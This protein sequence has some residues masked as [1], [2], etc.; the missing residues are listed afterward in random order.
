M[1]V[2]FAMQKR[3]MWPL[4]F[5]RARR[6]LLPLVFGILC[7]V[8][9]HVLI[10]QRYYNQDLVYAPGPGHL[11]FLANI[12]IYTVLLAPLLYILKRNRESRIIR[13]LAE[14]SKHPVG[15]LIIMIP[16][17]LETILVN[18]E[19]F[20]LYAG[21][22]HGFLYGLLAF[23]FGFWFALIEDAFRQLVCRW[24]WL[25][26][27]MASMLFT[28]RLVVFELQ[29]PD[30]MMSVESILWIFTALGFAAEYLDRS[31]RVLHYLSQA[32]YPVYIVHMIFLYLGSFLVFPM[33]IP[34][35]IKL[36]MLLAITIIASFAFYEVIIRR[37]NII[38]L[39]FGLKKIDKAVPQKLHV[40]ISYY[41]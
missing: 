28:V 21:T 26:A 16:F 34:A 10:W 37:R 17:V 31:G 18:P 24:R 12:F 1:G 38:R 30:Y 14:R 13:W 5:E 15:L 39:L 20:A 8:P 36:L 27:V 7:I 41:N 19:P 25:L 35:G 4:I 11:W 22:L 2:C 9:L 6:I 3:T 23:L 40:E 33:A 32:A 29:A